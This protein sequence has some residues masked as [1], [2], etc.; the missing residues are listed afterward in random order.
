MSGY[1]QHTPIEI[2]NLILSNTPDRYLKL[3]M[4]T[5]RFFA[6]VTTRYIKARPEFI[7]G[8]IDTFED[9]FQINP[10]ADFLKMCSNDMLYTRET[11][12]TRVANLIL[13]SLVIQNKHAFM[14]IM[15]N[16]TRW[17][18]A[19][20]YHS[21][22]A[23]EKQFSI[24]FIDWKDISTT[25][26]SG[27][28][29]VIPFS[30]YK[31]IIFTTILNA[32]RLDVF[33]YLLAPP[34][35]ET[36]S[37][38]L[39]LLANHNFMVDEDYLL[40]MTYRNE[41]DSLKYLYAN[42]KGYCKM[43]SDNHYKVLIYASLGGHLDLTTWILSIGRNGSND[44]IFGIA[45]TKAIEC[46]LRCNHVDKYTELITSH[47]TWPNHLQ[48]NDFSFESVITAN[49]DHTRYP[50]VTFMNVQPVSLAT[51][52]FCL[53]EFG[54]STEILHSTYHIGLFSTEIYEKYLPTCWPQKN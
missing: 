25:Y 28:T 22:P 16:S 26:L 41:Y 53:K 7:I 30:C 15:R 45:V 4:Q 31:K 9:L 35:P 17:Y 48:S 42:N 5:S 27:F 13:A 18:M 52:D 21:W 34:I 49:V 8:T 51:F 38:L 29:D 6:E 14:E 39:I 43:I 19:D 33:K 40:Q 2:I 3:F 1:L 47:P 36:K 11:Y 32:D 23:L 44:Y 12:Q 54:W 46:F 20:M 24:P 37:E 10:S 50:A